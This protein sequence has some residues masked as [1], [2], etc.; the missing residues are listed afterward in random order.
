MRIKISLEMVVC[1]LFIVVGVIAYMTI[2]W[3]EGTASP[4]LLRQERAM[5]TLD[6]QSM[7]KIYAIA[8]IV[9]STINILFQFTKRSREQRAAEEQARAEEVLDIG[10]MRMIRFRT[11]V[12]LVLVVAYA[13]LLPYTPFMP[14]TIVFLFFMLR[15]YGQKDIKITLPVS[16]AGAFCLWGLF[17]K[18]A[19]LPLGK[20]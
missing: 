11:A 13:L 17:I 15:I 18:L 4:F 1:A 14:A 2:G 6:Y 9:F 16:L 19:D 20:M 12:T 7:P 8:L 3:G 10:R 5:G